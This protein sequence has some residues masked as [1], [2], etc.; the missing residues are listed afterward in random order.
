MYIFIQ[1]DIGMLKAKKEIRIG[2]IGYGFM[3]KTHAWAITNLPFFFE[4]LPFTV[5]I[6]GVVT[7][8]MEKSR[9][10]AQALGA[11]AYETEDDLIASDVDVI[12]ICTPNICH[13]DTARKALLAGK[14][15][16]CEKPL[17]D[18]LENAEEMADLAERSGKICTAVFNNRHMAAVCRAKELI[19][20]GRLGR[21]LTYQ[22]EYLHNS[23]TDPEKKA[24]WKQ[25]ADVCGKG[26]VLFDLGSHILDL[27]VFLC[28]KIKIVNGKGQV[29][30][31][32][33]M[34]MDGNP[35]KT[36]ASEAFYLRTECENGAIGTLIA[37]KLAT[38]MNDDLR[39]LIHG[40]KGALSISLM[41]P[42]YLGFYDATAKSGDF[43]GECGFTRIECVGRY[44]APAGKF[45]SP[46]AASGWLRGHLMSMYH[47]LNAV[48]KGEQNSPSFA[49]AAYIQRVMNAA[50]RSDKSGRDEPV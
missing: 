38:G 6:T 9:A 40:T 7:R 13:A 25:T 16:Y 28:G 15:L 27:A 18:T 12:D 22:F 35:W 43:G 20:E 8:S 2:L 42:N 23:C 50:L 32:I 24:G 39:F 47:F 4:N 5:K 44:P 45:P 33:R 46:K 19:E 34:G 37:S 30:F 31:P 11:T 26:G 3:G 48:Y 1:E 21:I 14:H 29:A 10:V 36:D 17:A 49:E 41:D